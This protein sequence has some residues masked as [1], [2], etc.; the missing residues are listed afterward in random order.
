MN[1]RRKMIADAKFK[2]D[3]AWLKRDDE[4]TCSAEDADDLKAMG[5]AHDGPGD[6]T[7]KRQYRRRDMTA[8]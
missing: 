4:F 5:M 3:G 2:H 7:A 8:Q 1:E 6:E